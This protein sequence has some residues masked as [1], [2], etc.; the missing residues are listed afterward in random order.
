MRE[1]ETNEAIAK[2]KII[3]MQICKFK[4]WRLLQNYYAVSCDDDK[5]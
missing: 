5:L 4:F 1:S 2:L 3:K